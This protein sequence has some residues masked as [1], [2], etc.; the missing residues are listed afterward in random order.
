MDTLMQKHASTIQ[1]Y[2]NGY[3][4]LSRQLTAA[5][6]AALLPFRRAGIIPPG[7]TSFR[8]FKEKVDYI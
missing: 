6:M 3:E 2:I 8:S 4:W 7:T 5:H 1:V